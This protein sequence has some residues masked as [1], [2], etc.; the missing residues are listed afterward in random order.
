MFDRLDDIG[1]D[2]HYTTEIFGGHL[3]PDEAARTTRENLSA[4]LG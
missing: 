4:M 2:G 1:Y 3:N